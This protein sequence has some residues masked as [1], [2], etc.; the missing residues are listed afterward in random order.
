MTKSLH[1]PCLLAAAALVAVGS[2][3]SR[4]GVLFATGFED[5]ALDTVHGQFGWTVGGDGTD[6]LVVQTDGTKALRVAA[7]DGW[8]EE[9]RRV[10][11]APS[12]L[13]YLAVEL[14]FRVDDTVNAFWFM[15]INRTYE[16][17]DPASIFWYQDQM[18]SNAQPG[19]PVMPVL[20]GHWYHAG[21]EVD[22]FTGR[23]IGVNYQG[24]WMNEIDTAW[25]QPGFLDLVVFRG[26]SLPG[27]DPTTSYGLIIDNLWITDST[28]AITPAPGAGLLMLG[29][30]LAGRRRR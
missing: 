1:A 23:I 25:N 13:R 6:G 29:A 27:S 12:S 16:E 10:F 26:L 18:A 24:T 2:D 28:Q 21:I 3:P 4:A 7:R 17:A 14:D 8:G 30:L 9:V 11:D 19:L 5:Y 20:A 22:Q 15:D